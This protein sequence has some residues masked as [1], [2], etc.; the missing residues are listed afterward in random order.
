MQSLGL[1]LCRF[2]DNL[3]HTAVGNAAPPLCCVQSGNAGEAPFLGPVW[4]P[5]RLF[6]PNLHPPVADGLPQR[7]GAETRGCVVSA[8]P[9]GRRF[10][11]A[12]PAV[13]VPEGLL[14]EATFHWCSHLTF[15]PV[16]GVF[17]VG[18][19]WFWSRR[20]IE[21]SHLMP[22]MC[23]YSLLVVWNV[24]HG[25]TSTCARLFFCSSSRVPLTFV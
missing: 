15:P 25:T 6:A 23:L 22:G 24:L 3:P 12:L 19:L 8:M 14:P 1:V 13:G 18:F 2:V 7:M 21:R 5:R 16:L 10:R 9:Q 4:C 17:L 11:A 20:C